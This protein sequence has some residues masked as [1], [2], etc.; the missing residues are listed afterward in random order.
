MSIE[1]L[2][3]TP[4]DYLLKVRAR[5]KGLE[6][7]VPGRLHDKSVAVDFV[8]SL[9]ISTPTTYRTYS[10]VDDL[11]LAGLP[12]EFVVKPTFLSSSY[13]VM[14]LKKAGDKWF[15]GL[16]KQEHS[17]ESIRAIQQSHWHQSE[18]TNKQI[19]IE[20]RVIDA[21]GAFV[22][23]DWKFFAFQGRIGLIH[24]T[25]RDSP[26]NRHAFYEG[27]FTP[28]GADDTS[29]I[30]VNE[31]IVN[32]VA[33]SPPACW[34]RFLL[35]ARRISIATP[36][37]FVRVDMY[38]SEKGPV[39]GEFTLVPGTFFYE[40]REKMLPKMSGILGMMWEDAEREL[41]C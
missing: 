23:D 9:G 37:P 21:S 29:L 35:A 27:D 19:V 28:I 7:G 30:E 36:T 31:G 2:Q 18:S 40:D 1:A 17:E 41:R 3:N 26:R 12:D 38:Q 4:P 22:P 6:K 39:F 32:R 34:R 33:A 15:D 11:S 8:R 20:E 10:D 14:V 16:R 13:G 24:R 5:H 25:I